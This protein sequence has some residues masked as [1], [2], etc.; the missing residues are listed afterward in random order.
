M[1]TGSSEIKEADIKSIRSDEIKAKLKRNPLKR[2]IQCL[3]STIVLRTQ[4]TIDRETG[5]AKEE[6]GLQN[7]PSNLT[8][9]SFPASV[10]LFYAMTH[11][12]HMNPNR[13]PPR[14]HPKNVT[15]QTH[16]LTIVPPIQRPKSSK[17]PR[18]MFNT[19]KILSFQIYF[20]THIRL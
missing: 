15:S 6:K 17:N 1:I 13:K 11:L 14:L 9:L 19:C 2:T 5:I 12:L 7:Q 20:E 8:L 10:I 3:A 4:E 16:H 18:H